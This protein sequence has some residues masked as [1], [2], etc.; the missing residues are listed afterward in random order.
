ME[1]E[2]YIYSPETKA[3]CDYNGEEVEVSICNGRVVILKTKGRRVVY[4]KDICQYSKEAEKILKTEK[5]VE[6][7]RWSVERKVWTHY[8]YVY[9]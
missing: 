6:V 7:P 5:I 1:D 9:E 2:R 4:A 3:V 8:K